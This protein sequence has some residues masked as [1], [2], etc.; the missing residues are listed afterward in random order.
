M[1]ARQLARVAKAPFV[2][3]GNAWFN[4]PCFFWPAK[5]GQPVQ[6]TAAA[7][8]LLLINETLDAATPYSGASKSAGASRARSLI[9]GVG[10]TTHAGSL[11][12]VACTDNTI[13][14]YLA[15]G[16]L[17]KRVAGNRSDKRCEPVPQPAPTGLAS[18]VAAASGSSQAAKERGAV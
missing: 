3:W 12:G 17:P 14:D 4:A 2:T 8:R 9:E 15:S 5:A 6:S 1:A 10:G 18:S 11:S 7:H 13:A 16:A